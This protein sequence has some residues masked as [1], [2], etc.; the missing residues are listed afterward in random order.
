MKQ[1]RQGE[2]ERL[3]DEAA[4][5]LGCQCLAARAAIGHATHVS[6]DHPEDF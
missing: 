6:H 3:S 2:T 1:C 4:M 5:H